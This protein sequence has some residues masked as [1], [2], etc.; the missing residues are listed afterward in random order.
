[1]LNRMSIEFCLLYRRLRIRLFGRHVLSSIR[2]AESRDFHSLIVLS[3]LYIG[4]TQHRTYATDLTIKKLNLKLKIRLRNTESARTVVRLKLIIQ[5]DRKLSTFGSL[6]V[7]TVH[8]DNMSVWFIPPYTTL[9]YSKTGVYRGI[10]FFLFL[11]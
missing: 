1:M 8:P 5:C 2:L 11:L 4:S 9:L 10:Y 3:M 6:Y 7:Y